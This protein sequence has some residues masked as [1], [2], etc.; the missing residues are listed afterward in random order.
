LA[1]SEWDTAPGGT[2]SNFIG[3]F[4][5]AGLSGIG[6][7]SLSK[8]APAI[9]GITYVLYQLQ[10]ATIT[11]AIIFGSVA[12]RVR[13][14][15]SML[16]V[17][18]WTTLV[19]DPAAYWTWAWRGWMRNM[20]CI[21]TTTGDAPC[22]IGGLDF[23]GGG[24]V[25]IASGFAGLAFCIILG[26]RRRVGE[27]EFNPNSLVNVFIG[28]AFIWFGWFAF[29]G[30]SAAAGTARASMASAVTQIAAA[31]GSLTWPLWDYIWT[32]K[33]SG[34]GFCSGAVSALVAITPASG[35]V[36][37]W[38]AIV[39]GGTAGIVCNMSCR[40]KGFFGFDDAL[41]AFGLHGIGGF[42]GNVLT[43]VFASK[44]VASLDATT[45]V[46]GGWIEGNFKQILYQLGGS[47]V[48][49]AYSFVLSFVILYTIN[50]IPGLHLRPLE[51]DEL[52]GG[53]LGEM[54]EVAY[55]LVS[56][57]ITEAF[58]ERLSMGDHGQAKSEATMQV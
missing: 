1:F 49:A 4:Q 31:S 30:G 8:T 39:L 38:A 10:F 57:V 40:V 22:G 43:G 29:N 25:H 47:S 56:G 12:E 36:A 17:F 58:P 28:T 11:A 55:E 34:L 24:P 16:F 53:D 37:P 51:D 42:Y 35:Y 54:G 23:A 5:Y 7:D 3:N 15:P 21:S 19:Y 33:M 18:I 2:G 48:I 6:F 27:E 14:I 45:T 50:K 9:S 13:I 32:G 44:W 26:K 20:D 41:D 52:L 46:M